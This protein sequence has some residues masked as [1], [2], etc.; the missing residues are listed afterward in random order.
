MAGVAAEPFERRDRLGLVGDV[1]ERVAAG[2]RRVRPD[3]RLWGQRR[4]KGHL[5]DTWLRVI[6]HVDS[7]VTSIPTSMNLQSHKETLW[8]MANERNGL[9]TTLEVVRYIHRQGQLRKDSGFV[10]CD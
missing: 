9:R 6:L 10:K 2:G 4:A 5:C 7:P 1:R 8:A 3:V